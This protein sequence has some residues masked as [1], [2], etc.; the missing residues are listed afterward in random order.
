MPASEPVDQ[1]APSVSQE[2]VERILNAA[3]R[4]M[5]R[6]APDTPRVSDIVAEAGSSNKT[7]Y[8]LFSGK[9]DLIIA[10]MTR[11]VAVIAAEVRA[12]MAGEADPAQQIARWVAAAMS[13]AANPRN[14]SVSRVALDQ[15]S[16]SANRPV[17]DGEIMAPM[18]ALLTK[19]VAAL[20]RTELEA[21]LVFL[22]TMGTMRRFYGSAQAPSDDDVDHLTR[23]C[24]RALGAETSAAP[25]PG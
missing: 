7:F 20:G 24:L 9:D 5:E 14:V 2:E 15:M 16:V 21:D 22:C 3:V 17:A 18:R 19:P 1:E 12:Q 23:F 10:L 13:P 4:V 25:Q 8:R 11:G 6:V